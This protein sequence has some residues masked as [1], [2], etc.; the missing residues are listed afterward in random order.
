MRNVK[1][2]IGMVTTFVYFNTINALIYT[3]LTVTMSPITGSVGATILS[4]SIPCLNAKRT[5][6]NTIGKS[7]M[8]EIIPALVEIK[9][10]TIGFP[11]FILKS[12]ENIGA[13]IP[14]TNAIRAVSVN[15]ANIFCLIISE[16]LNFGLIIPR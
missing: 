15:D 1:I 7:T 5:I 14:I 12:S 10:S 4:G 3:A 16:K 8:E 13:D 9:D 6:K 2:M 11:P